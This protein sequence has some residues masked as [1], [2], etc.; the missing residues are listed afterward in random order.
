MTNNGT[1]KENKKTE[2]LINFIN[3]NCF[4]FK[5]FTIRTFLYYFEFL[6]GI[7][8]ICHL[9][10][11]FIFCI[12]NIMDLFF[13]SKE[14][15]KKI[16]S[17]S[18][19][20]SAILYI[21]LLIIFYFI[22]VFNLKLEKKEKES[23]SLK[24]K[25]LIHNLTKAN[26]S[27]IKNINKNSLDK[28][29]D[30]FINNFLLRNSL[31]VFILLY[32]LTEFS[33]ILEFM[34]IYLEFQ[35]LPKDLQH[36]LNP[37]FH[38]YINKGFFTFIYKS[39]IRNLSVFSVKKLCIYMLY[40]I[41]VQYLLLKKILNENYLQNWINKSEKNTTN[42][43]YKNSTLNS[44]FSLFI[45]LPVILALC[46]HK[47]EYNQFIIRDFIEL[48]KNT[49]DITKHENFKLLK[50]TIKENEFHNIFIK[51][52]LD[53]DTKLVITSL[54]YRIFFIDDFNETNINI[55]FFNDN[56]IKFLKRLVKENYFMEMKEFFNEPHNNMKNILNQLKN[57]L[58]KTETKEKEVIVINF[59]EK[60]FKLANK[61]SKFDFS[62]FLLTINILYG[63]TRN[64]DLN[65]ILNSL[66][67]I[68]T[69]EFEITTNLC[70]K[71]SGLV[72]EMNKKY[73]DYFYDN[74]EKN[75][76]L[77]DSYKILA[78][79]FLTDYKN[80]K[81]DY[82]IENPSIKEISFLQITHLLPELE[83][84]HFLIKNVFK[85][86]QKNS[87]FFL[88][89]FLK[90]FCSLDNL[91]NYIKYFTMNLLNVEPFYNENKLNDY[92]NEFNKE[93]IEKLSKDDAD[94]D[95]FTL[96]FLSI[97]LS[98]NQL[99]NLNKYDESHRQ[100]VNK[101]KINF[102]IYNP[103]VIV[104]VIIGIFMVQNLINEFV[105]F[106]D[107]LENKFL[108]SYSTKYF[109]LL[110]KEI[111]IRESNKLKINNFYG[112]KLTSI[113]INAKDVFYN[114]PRFEIN[115]KL[116]IQVKMEESQKIYDICNLLINSN[117]SLVGP[118]GSG[119]TSLAILL[120]RLVE[121][122]NF[123][124]ILNFEAFGENFSIAFSELEQEEIENYFLF[125]P[126]ISYLPEHLSV[127]DL[128]DF[129]TKDEEL[130]IE[131]SKQLNLPLKKYLSRNLNK[132]SG[133][134][135]FRVLFIA[136][137]SSIIK[138][139]LHGPALLIIDELAGLDPDLRKKVYN[140]LFKKFSTLVYK[141]SL[142]NTLIYEE[143]IKASNI[144]LIKSL[145]FSLKEKMML[146]NPQE[147]YK[148][149]ITH[150][151]KD[152]KDFLDKSLK[153]N[154]IFKTINIENLN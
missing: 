55:D 72:N 139:S 69:S 8:L 28:A 130:L 95:K 1:I 44:L 129:F 122:K 41:L 68:N 99:I 84:F 81:F 149:C 54:F 137:L 9:L 14:R 102:N 4:K 2:Y 59:F 126:Q 79:T 107:E 103:Y 33:L 51:D 134:E 113:E 35:I 27:I 128:C 10:S 53:H 145:A 60:I 123:K 151:P 125:L 11:F 132:I 19:I 36:A 15:N 154:P 100:L 71:F 106:I 86:L 119:K 152:L 16:R 75:K 136:M 96:S 62:D 97:L 48:K 142:K 25:D 153:V 50:Q 3:K 105:P 116:E 140:L 141:Y 108:Y 94:Y 43:F 56:D 18:F 20:L 133:G 47:I 32:F 57:N 112:A 83:D 38:L 114:N 17:Y 147:P 24:K 7:I 31:Y 42:F 93:L 61:F 117:M 90:E 150:T 109:F 13:S 63:H 6:M 23:C 89:N 46:Q 148:I 92:Y 144:N 85:P 115:E 40:I 49:G 12:F 30:I 22:K 104:L 120:S 37:K 143:Q 39:L 88:L 76:I 29:Y 124:V 135:R 87:N 127:K 45:L 26:L 5:K 98:Q 110:F 34:K 73:N 78:K 121:N 58:T 91:I 52:T 65:I 111:P 77:G 21:I 82:K 80:L 118:S 146:L 138:K 74:E 70:N 64:E 67:F 131:L 101:L 66:S